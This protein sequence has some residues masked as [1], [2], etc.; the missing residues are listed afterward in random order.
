MTSDQ[1]PGRHRAPGQGPA[2]AEFNADDALAAETLG[3][4]LDIAEWGAKVSAGRPFADLPSLQA[5]GSA[6]AAGIT[7]EQVAGALDRHPR[8]GERQAAAA[9]TGAESAW[10]GAEQSGVRAAHA[11]ALASGNAS[12][13]KRFGHIFLICAAGL[14]GEQI[15]AELDSRLAN[16]PE[17]EKPVVIEQLRRISALR[18]AKAVLA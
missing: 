3:A 9:G 2:L 6:A 7:W 4:C 12:Y 1:G 11:D 8:I 18:L 10:S 5:A 13:E 15:L 16:D 17:A 14:S